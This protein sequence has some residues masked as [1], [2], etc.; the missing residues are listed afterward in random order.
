MQGGSEV[1]HLSQIGSE[2]VRALGSKASLYLAE[3]RWQSAADTSII[4][5]KFAESFLERVRIN[6]NWGL[7]VGGLHA[8]RKNIS[9]SE[10]AHK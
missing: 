6:Q 2:E 1:I 4:F 8:N 3:G 7:R 5:Q 9:S 10:H